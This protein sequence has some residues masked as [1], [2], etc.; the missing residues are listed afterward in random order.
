MEVP[1]ER[2]GS[3]FGVL[4]LKC[5]DKCMGRFS[6]KAALCL[7]PCL[8]GNLGGTTREFFRPLGREDSIFFR[9]DNHGRDFG[10]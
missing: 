9:R 10:K 6:A 7:E 5:M 3:R 1:A 8:Q 2:L 4:G